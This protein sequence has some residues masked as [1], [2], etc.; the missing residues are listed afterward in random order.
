MLHLTRDLLFLPKFYH[1]ETIVEFEKNSIVEISMTI[2][3][4]M[5]FFPWEII[6]FVPCW[7]LYCNFLRSERTWKKTGIFG[8]AQVPE[9]RHSGPGENCHFFSN[10]ANFAKTLQNTKLSRKK[11]N[12]HP[13]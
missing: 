3:F 7:L 11:K 2:S 10:S 4:L 8:W 9:Q 5:I 6:D 12:T 1:F 13:R